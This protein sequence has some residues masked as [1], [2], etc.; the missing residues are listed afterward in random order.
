MLLYQ[1]FCYWV[2]TEAT[3]RDSEGF[4]DAMLPF[5]YCLHSPQICDLLRAVKRARA[6]TRQRASTHAHAY[7]AWLLSAHVSVEACVRACIY[8]A[9]W[10]NVLVW[11]HSLFS[12]VSITNHVILCCCLKYDGQFEHQFYR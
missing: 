1:L 7:L 2:I 12:V 5:L 4:D 9:W 11:M 6:S 10:L 3:R 8:L